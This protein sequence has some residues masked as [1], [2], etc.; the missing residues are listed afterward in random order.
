MP[1]NLANTSKTM[2]NWEINPGRG[3]PPSSANE[4]LPQARTKTGD[5]NGG[6]TK[7]RPEEAPAVPHK[8]AAG[9]SAREMVTPE[10]RVYRAHAALTAP[11]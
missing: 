4:T 1:R 8:Q 10:R 9:K 6:K 11:M 2:S 7:Q 5:T 3:A